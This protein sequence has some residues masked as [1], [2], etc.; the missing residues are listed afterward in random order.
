MGYAAA[1]G[2]Q[3]QQNE[4]VA[5]GISDGEHTDRYYNLQKRPSRMAACALR[6]RSIGEIHGK[7]DKGIKTG[8][9]QDASRPWCQLCLCRFAKAD[10]SCPE[11]KLLGEEAQGFEFFVQTAEFS[12]ED[13][14]VVA[15][16]LLQIGDLIDPAF[17][18]G[19]PLGVGNG[20]GGAAVAYT[21]GDRLSFLQL[22]EIV[23]FLNTQFVYFS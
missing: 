13:F 17:H 2:L 11:G 20:L 4:A 23:C 6:G 1:E 5:V 19:G 16:F 10:V 14:F 8:G 18:D 7:A 12:A 21:P 9:W 22:R 15:L 3:Q